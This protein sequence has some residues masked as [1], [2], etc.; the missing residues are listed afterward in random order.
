LAAAF[1]PDGSWLATGSD[2]NSARIWDAT[3]G[4]KLLEVRH[5]QSVTSV[6]FSSD[7]TRLATGSHDYTA[8]IWQIG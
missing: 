6:A 1:S 5:D 3:S 8:R 7:G 2:D 4:G